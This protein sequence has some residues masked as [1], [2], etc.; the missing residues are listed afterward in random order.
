MLQCFEK[1]GFLK[2]WRDGASLRNWT[3][4]KIMQEYTTFCELV[5][6]HLRQNLWMQ[7][8][9]DDSKHSFLLYVHPAFGMAD[10]GEMIMDW[11]LRRT[12]CKFLC[13]SHN[14]EIETGRYARPRILR[15]QRFCSY[16]LQNGVRVLGDEWHAFDVCLNFEMGRKKAKEQ[17]SQILPDM[18]T[19]A[20]SITIT[21]VLRDL[22]KHTKDARQKVWRT[23]AVFTME[24]KNQMQK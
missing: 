8:A 20:N 21:K 16:C 24:I 17:I 6:E 19:S 5:D 14:L 23:I 7:L 3:R 9:S 1:I 15:S 12:L 13:S 10:L 18:P 2:S 11:Y 4:R 22:D